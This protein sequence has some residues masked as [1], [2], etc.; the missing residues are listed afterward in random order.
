[1]L[2]DLNFQKG[3]YREFFDVFDMK[4]NVITLLSTCAG[5][6]NLMISLA[7]VFGALLGE[8][9]SELFEFKLQCT[10]RQR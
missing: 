1:V 9:V 7:A 3:F 6:L 2:K 4:P 5:M 8:I 10:S